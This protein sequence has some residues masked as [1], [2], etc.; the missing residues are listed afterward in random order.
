M[1]KPRRQDPAPSP[2]LT[3]CVMAKRILIIDDDDD[4]L[5]MFRIIFQDSGFDVIFSNKG[6]EYHEIQVMHP[7]LVLLDVKIKGYERTGDE[8]CRQVKHNNGSL[9][10]ILISAEE[11]LPELALECRADAYFSKP[12]RIGELK[13]K[14]SLL[15][16]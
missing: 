15:T 7:D 5:D 12:F 11:H 14:I 4:I 6:M 3:I 1:D 9:P 10:I 13:E 16:S 8:I 2:N